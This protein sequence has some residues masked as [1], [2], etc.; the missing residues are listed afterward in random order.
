MPTTTT[1]SDLETLKGGLL[2]SVDA[3]RMLWTL[4]DRGFDVKLG[5]GRRFKVLVAP[6]NGLT[7]QDKAAIHTHRNALA[8]LVRY[9]DQVVGYGDQVPASWVAVPGDGLPWVPDGDPAD[10]SCRE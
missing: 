5:D 3:L 6:A 8:E 10:I 2:V 7:D 4:E 1:V 9:V